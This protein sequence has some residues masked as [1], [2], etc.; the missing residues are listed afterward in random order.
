MTD[1][2]DTLDLKA[3]ECFPG[4]VVRKDLVS[5]LKGQVNVPT[6]VLEYLLG[7]YCASGDEEIIQAGLQEVKRVLNEHYVHPDQS[8][9][10]KAQVREKSR[11]RVIDKVKVRPVETE[12]KSWAQLV[13]LGI[14]RV[15]IGDDLVNRYER[16]LGGG[17]WAVVDLAYDPMLV[18]RC[19]LRPFAIAELRPIQLA[20]GR[21]LEEVQEGRA[22]L[23]RDEWLDLILRSVGIEPLSL[24]HRL[25]MLY[26]ARLIP[27]V[28]SNW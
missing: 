22:H 9:W 24:P 7:K 5:T 16:L 13:N 1:Q 18:H 27:L 15:Y 14:D 2:L 4:R 8:E 19:E 21:P 25:K 10:F 23:S 12:D 17:V 28:E 3:L 20:G 6:Y 11:H 26:L